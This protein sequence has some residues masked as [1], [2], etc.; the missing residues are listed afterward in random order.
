MN[1]K[2]AFGRPLDAD[3]EFIVNRWATAGRYK[4]IIND[5]K[6]GG[7]YEKDRMYFLSDSIPCDESWNGKHSHN[8]ESK[9]SSYVFTRNARYYRRR[10]PLLWICR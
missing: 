9:L 6:D 10:S 3:L 5:I 4:T 7:Y 8:C 1:E 2:E